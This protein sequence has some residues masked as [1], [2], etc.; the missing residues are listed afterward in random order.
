MRWRHER[1]QSTHQFCAGRCRVDAAV[2]L[3][4]RVGVGRG[5]V[6]RAIAV[7]RQAGQPFVDDGL[8]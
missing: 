5:N 2:I 6:I 3:G 7:G 8:V 4:G 1:L